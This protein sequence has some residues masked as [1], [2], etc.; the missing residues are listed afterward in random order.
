[1]KE[2]DLSIPEPGKTAAKSDS[3][4]LDRGKALLRKAQQAVGGA[5]K[6]AAVKDYTQSVAAAITTPQGAMN[7]KQTNQWMSSGAMRQSQ[8]LPFGKIVAFYDGKTNWL[9]SPQG[10]IDMPPQV[11]RQMQGEKMRSFF[12]LLLADRNPAL[13]V[14]AVAD[15]AIEIAAKG[16]DSVRVELDPT[17][18]PARYT[19]QS[20]GMQ[21]PTSVTS[22]FSDWRDVGGIRL[23]YKVVIEQGGKKFAEATVSEWKINSGL[24]TE[25]LSKKP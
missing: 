3:A 1:V 8:E 4:S 15:N 2:I 19:Y 14:N 5:D 12:E 10:T 7:A 18:L 9:A 17:G 20:M 23:P 16:A 11:L 6:L 22:N 24:T 13:T 21:G 25:E